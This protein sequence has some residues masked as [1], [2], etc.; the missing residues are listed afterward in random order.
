ME[1]FIKIFLALLFALFC[2]YGVVGL[3]LARIKDEK[4]IKSL[5]FIIPIIGYNI[6]QLLYWLWYFLFEN[7][8][9]SFYVT[10][11]FL[12]F[13]NFVYLF[14]SCRKERSFN[15]ILKRFLPVNKDAYLIVVLVLI[16]ILSSWQYVAVGEGHYYHSGNEDFFDGINGGVA[17]LNNMPLNSMPQDF[18]YDWPLQY[19]SQAFWRILLGVG[20]VDGFLIQAILNL[21]LI[22]IG[23]F[24]LAK[25]VFNANHRTALWI[26]FWSVAANF[27]LTTFLN[28]HIG[29]LI[30]ASMAPVLLG[31]II[32]WGR[33]ELSSY[34]LIIAALLL[35]SIHI[36]Y[37]GPIF[38]L[39]IP[40]ALL[41]IIERVILPL[42]LHSKFL[43][44]LGIKKE[45][46]TQKF[47]GAIV[48]HRTILIGL[49]T[50]T[51]AILI[52]ILVY[53]YFE[54]RRV[55]AI[56][57]TNVSWKISLFKEMFPI[58]WGIYPSGSTGTLSALPIF[59]SNE[60]I[61]TIALILAGFLT[62]IS[63]IAALKCRKNKSMH[64]LF[65]YALLFL[66]FFIMMRYFWGSPY[67]FYKFL[68]VN[69]FIVV[70]ILFLWLNDFLRSHR[71]AWLKKL[72]IV[73][74][75]FVGS[76][77]IIWNIS[78]GVDYYLRPYNDKDKIEN[79]FSHTTKEQLSQSSLDI[80]NF[81]YDLV[82][83]YIFAEH[84]Y[85]R[86]TSRQD[87]KYLIQL[88]NFGNVHHNSISKAQEKYNNG[89]LKLVEIPSSDIISTTTNYEPEHAGNININ[90]VGN[91]ISVKRGVVISS[92]SNLLDFLGTSKNRSRTFI[93]ITDRDI[94][95]ILY[96]ALISKGMKLQTNAFAADWFIQVKGDKSIF[97]DLKNSKVVWDDD[98]FQ[99]VE[100]RSVSQKRINEPRQKLDL[101]GLTSEIKKN[102][103]KIYIDMPHSEHLYLYLLQFL[104]ENEINVADDPA[105]TEL[106]CRI[107]FNSSSGVRNYST[108]NHAGE[109]ILWQSASF[110]IFQR[111]WEVQ[112]L[113]V[114]VED[115][116]ITQNASAPELPLRFL[117]NISKGDFQVRISKITPRA[118]F[119]RLLI[120]PGPSIDFSSFALKAV[121]LNNGAEK[122]FNVT[123]PKTLID[124]NVNDFKNQ[125]DS[126]LELF[127]EGENLV[128]RSLLPLD[129]RYLNYQIQAVELTD[130]IDYYSD[131]LISALN[132]KIPTRLDRF[133]NLFIKEEAVKDIISKKDSLNIFLGTGWFPLEEYDKQTYRWT[134]K[135]AAEIILNNIDERDKIAEIE[136]EP[137]PGC[138]SAPLDI[139]IFNKNQLIKSDVVEGRKKIQFQIPQEAITKENKQVILRLVTKTEN[140]KIASDPRI[141]NYRVF[142]IALKE[143]EKK[144]ND[145][146]IID[147]KNDDQIQLGNGWYSYEIFNGESFRWAGKD[148]AEFILNNVG[149]RDKIAEIELEPG[150][151]CGSA[152]LDIKIFNKNQLI[153]SDV[154]EGRKKIQ[155]Q[156]PQEAI[157]KENKQVILRLVTKTENKK[158]ASD[159]RILN[160]RVFNI[161]LKEVEKKKNDIDIIDEKNDDQIQLGNGWYSYEIFNGESF[162]WA[163][164]DP[165]EII[166][167]K[168]DKD[169]QKVKLELEPG[170]GCAGL[171]LRL[172]IYL[173]NKLLQQ[174]SFIGKE[175]LFIDI[176]KA[177]FNNANNR[178]MIKLV[179]VSKNA[180]ISSDD[181]IL[182]FRVFKISLN[183]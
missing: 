79:F 64:F 132:N 107:I 21:F 125:S 18:S 180:A 145:I 102:G 157:T 118:Q 148:P 33:K 9:I 26:S 35:Y 126:T 161:A 61:N 168:R 82:F 170:P 177:S 54:P 55:Q 25:Y 66:P 17:Y 171:P 40:A 139:K 20:G 1:I 44:F 98:I 121:S 110:N 6:S 150:P 81:L 169:Y 130:Q 133:L 129:D 144:K 134:G 153:K 115:R 127:L 146:D 165:A 96:Q 159:P 50:I 155:F 38:F 112:L 92:L 24:W 36:T 167:T 172:K 47:T 122:I 45:D 70:I 158:I 37:P 86:L 164:K 128:G 91:E 100:I 32:L 109:K 116:V 103:N 78:I 2:G 162:R 181:R 111:A 39:L 30:Y 152:P 182:N 119:V 104:K 136:L 13:I 75:V 71:K 87:A 8:I 101:S 73:F 84:G 97:A 56:L 147:E 166:I 174:K 58:F 124:L 85:P 106:F 3:F 65:T 143:V 93:D 10:I 14:L 23:V 34:W 5:F 95:F 29:S 7:H 105:K 173:N 53:D 69:F 43:E 137:G 163:G 27:Y 176:S 135:D 68:Y 99:I 117:S 16:F 90:W 160:Y 67:Y 28:G 41:V 15:N 76:L 108:V 77:N 57:R 149:E 80:P 60:I 154:V 12:T 19:S 83:R 156:I 31:I 51:A 142:N 151:G 113:K 49:L 4:K 123:S 62:F 131:Y 46:T 175:I 48:W 42:N 138:G 179:P 140:K 72:V 11:S 94:Y 178:C 74:L 183:N 141:L 52:T 59:I 89:L 22:S 114:P 63:I 120:S 88:E